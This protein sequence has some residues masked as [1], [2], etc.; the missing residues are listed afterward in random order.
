MPFTVRTSAHEK[1][2]ADMANWQKSP[3][4][5]R[6][7]AE[8][9]PGGRVKVRGAVYAFPDF[10]P[11]CGAKDANCMVAIRSTAILQMRFWGNGFKLAFCKR[12]KRMIRGVEV[13]S[14]MLGTFVLE[15]ARH[16]WHM[17]RIEGW[18]LAVVI[19]IGCDLLLREL[20]DARVKIVGY[21]K[22]GMEVE[23]EDMM[24]ADRFLA[25]NA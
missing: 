5:R 11:R 2:L 15:S 9:M 21:D 1:L 19:G 8:R 16:Q 17:P 20:V 3:E 23:F 18:I 14:G 13:V 22:D 6:P 25:L 4:V 12:C 10:C 7:K 24:Y